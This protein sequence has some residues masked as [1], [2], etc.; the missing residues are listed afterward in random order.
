M[1][2][3]TVFY[4]LSGVPY[5]VVGSSELF[6]AKFPVTFLSQQLVDLIVQ[7]PNPELP[8]TSWTG[9]RQVKSESDR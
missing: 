4:V 6:D 1:V 3:V 2:T 7:I 9:E 5:R 8:Q